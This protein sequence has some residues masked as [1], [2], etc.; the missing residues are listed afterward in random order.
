MLVSGSVLPGK[1]TNVL[2]KSMVGS[3]VS[4][5]IEIV[6]FRGH[7]SFRDCMCFFSGEKTKQPLSTFQL[8]AI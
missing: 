7:V 2:Q 6:P 5:P 3:D 1:R 4:F 8:R